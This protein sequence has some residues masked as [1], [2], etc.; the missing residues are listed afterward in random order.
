MGFKP[1]DRI[2][3]IDLDTVIT[4]P[5]DSLFERDE[6]F[7]IMQGGSYQPCPYD[8]ALWLQHAY[9]NEHVWNDFTLEAASKV[10]YHEFPDDQA[11]L[12][13]KI[14]NAAGWKCGEEVFVYQKP[15]WPK[16]EDLPERAKLV[17]F[18]GK[19]R[20]EQIQDLDW[21]KENWIGDGEEN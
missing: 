16:G 11:W 9:T 12:A 14:P 15:G 18:A 17:T 21:V 13:A 10:P 1:G 8:G 7:V 6:D 5:L 3:Q 19:R 20:P 2:V 4:G